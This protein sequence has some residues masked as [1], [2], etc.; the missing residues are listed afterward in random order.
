MWRQ[1]A[2]FNECV[3]IFECIEVGSLGWHRRQPRGHSLDAQEFGDRGKIERMVGDSVM[4]DAIHLQIDVSGR[5]EVDVS[6]LVWLR[7]TDLDDDSV[8]PRHC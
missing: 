5:E 2:R 6:V 4:T 7:F 3:D 8:R 1:H